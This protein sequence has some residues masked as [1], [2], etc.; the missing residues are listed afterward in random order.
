MSDNGFVRSTWL[1]VGI[2]LGLASVLLPIPVRAS[3]VGD[4]AG[5]TFGSFIFI[6]FFVLLCLAAFWFFR[7]PAKHAED[8]VNT[9][10]G[11][12]ADPNDRVLFLQMYHSKSPKSVVLAWVLTAFLSPT[13]SYLYQSKWGLAAIAFFTFQGLGVWWIVSIFSMPS[14]VMGSNKK[15][16]DQ[17]FNEL[18][19]ARPNALL[20]AASVTAPIATT[21]ASYSPSELPGT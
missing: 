15:L 14:E 2:T 17:A 20:I 8:H 7:G 9:L 1:P 4:A 18:R 16:A 10:A 6:G 21:I 19:L 3:G 12:I 13:I 11:Q 5:A